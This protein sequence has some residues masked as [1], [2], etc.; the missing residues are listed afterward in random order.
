MRS[1]RIFRGAIDGEWIASFEA[2]CRQWFAAFEARVADERE[3]ATY[4]IVAR[5]GIQSGI[6]LSP[7]LFEQ[8]KPPAGVEHF[9][10][11]ISQ[12]PMWNSIGD[13]GDLYLLRDYCSIR[14]QRSDEDAKALGWHQDSAV[15]T[16]HVRPAAFEVTSCGLRSRQSTVTLPLF[17]S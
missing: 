10:S 9:F 1:F 17:K 2:L 4:P 15:V 12:M 5:F 6:P 8:T 11:A 16:G 13:K 3:V 14:R 7:T